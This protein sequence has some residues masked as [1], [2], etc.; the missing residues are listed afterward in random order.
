MCQV[1]NK[2]TQHLSWLSRLNWS[3]ETTKSGGALKQYILHRS[4]LSRPVH[5][6]AM[7]VDVVRPAS[8]SYLNT[9]LHGVI[10]LIRHEISLHVAADSCSRLQPRLVAQIYGHLL[11]LQTPTPIRSPVQ[12]TGLRVNNNIECNLI[13]D[14]LLSSE[15]AQHDIYKYS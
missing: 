10:A 1:P 11:A 13:D 5:L 7:Q 9:Y 8:L 14:P 12:S 6:P 15:D 2:K 3:K 4:D